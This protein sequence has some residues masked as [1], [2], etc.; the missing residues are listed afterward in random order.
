MYLNII[1]QFLVRIMR[2][3]KQVI[4]SIGFKIIS[5][6]VSLLT[7][8]FLLSILGHG[9]YS[10]WVVAF[11]FVNWILIL[12]FG[13][14]NSIRNSL[15]ANYYKDNWTKISKLV[16][17]VF[18]ISFIL[19]FLFLVIFFLLAIFVKFDD[20]LDALIVF[21]IFTFPL[22]PVNQILH[23]FNKSHVVIFIQMSISILSLLIIFCL[24]Y[25]SKVDLNELY[26]IYGVV[27]LLIYFF[28]FILI[29]Y[30]YSNLKLRLH[31]LSIKRALYLFRT[32]IIFFLLQLI[33][34]FLFSSD[35]LVISIFIGENNVL[36]Y[37]IL[38]RFFNLYVIFCLVFAAPIWS[39]IRAYIATDN[40]TSMKYFIKR[41]V[42]FQL[43]TVPLLIILAYISKYFIDFWLGDVKI[44]N[45]ISN[46]EIYC[47][48]V[49]CWVYV[50]YSIV[51]NISNG[52][53]K[54]SSQIWIGLVCC[55]IKLPLTYLMIYLYNSYISVVIV[56]TLCLIPFP[57]YFIFYLLKGNNESISYNNCKE[58]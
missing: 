37:D 13:L 49:L 51:A 46:I 34:M 32:G 16:S 44:T 55:I 12:D 23:A 29:I 31:Y 3:V 7:V 56:S 41:L 10:R 38:M 21:F 15:V 33:V 57:I 50:T 14:G 53:S 18:F 48:A 9:D 43:L 25:Y 17:N 54:I 26:Y 30:C 28:A 40:L 20:A 4:G 1:I 2:F 8:R 58:Q 6:I 24:N 39:T 42:I 52:M 47:I 36:H 35:R 27:T 19:A 11:N 5:L 22:L 45:G